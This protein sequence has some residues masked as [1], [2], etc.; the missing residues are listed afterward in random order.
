ML[1]YESISVARRWCSFFVKDGRCTSFHRRSAAIII[2][3]MNHFSRA[4]FVCIFVQ[5]TSVRRVRVRA[6]KRVRN[7]RLG[8]LALG[9][10]RRGGFRYLLFHIVIVRRFFR[11]N[12]ALFLSGPLFFRTYGQPGGVF[13]SVG[14]VFRTYGQDEGCFLSVGPGGRPARVGDRGSSPR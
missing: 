7:V 14:L 4:L 11:Q 5:G 13:L 10:R 2:I 8:A 12:S 9:S 6:H 1:N 3:L